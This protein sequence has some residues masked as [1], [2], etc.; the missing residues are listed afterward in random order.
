M[1]T[2]RKKILFADDSPS[3]R[4]FV[5]L[6]LSKD[7]DVDTACDGE[8]A[9][10][11]AQKKCYD[12]FLLDLYMPKIDGISL[13]K[14]IRLDDNTRFRPAVVISTEADK[15]LLEKGKNAGAT[16]WIV[17]PFDKDYLLK[18]VK[19]ILFGKGI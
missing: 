2:N 13:L 19:H 16:G 10:R 5:S 17:K 11:L 3:M 14:K 4:L 6:S 12:L 9:L 15:F 8:E 1:N 18:T 7:F